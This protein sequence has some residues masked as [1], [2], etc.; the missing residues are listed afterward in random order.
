MRGIVFEDGAHVAAALLGCFVH[1]LC[2]RLQ[3]LVCRCSD[4]DASREN[5]ETLSD[6]EEGLLSLREDVERFLSLMR[7]KCVRFSSVDFR[8]LLE[9]VGKFVRPFLRRNGVRLRINGEGEAFAEPALLRSA[10]LNLIVNAVEAG[11]KEV[12]IAVQ[13]EVDDVVVTVDDDGRP[14]D[15]T[16]NGLGLSSVKFVTDIHEG[17]L[18][19]GQLVKVKM[20]IS[21]R[22][23]KK[24]D[25]YCI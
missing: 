24:I 17:T 2:N 23:N 15:C 16:E 5:G 14:F 10:L 13:E 9:D 8:S 20:R 12:V 7:K 19:V 18:T 21:K 22:I 11:A 3:M 1:D 4:K 6:V 25:S